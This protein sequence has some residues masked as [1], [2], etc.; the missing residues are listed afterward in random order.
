[1]NT[2]VMQ[3]ERPITVPMAG[4]E[5]HMVMRAMRD[6]IRAEYK[7]INDSRAQYQK[8]KREKDRLH[9]EDVKQHAMLRVK[10]AQDFLTYLQDVAKG[11]VLA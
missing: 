4:G 11:K 10:A 7:A 3:R 6:Y 1:M 9:A 8:T 5:I 2:E